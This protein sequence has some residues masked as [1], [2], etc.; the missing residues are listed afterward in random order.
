MGADPGDERFP[1]RTK[2]SSRLLAARFEQF[3]L[4]QP[5]SPRFCNARHSRSRGRGRRA[6]ARP[7]K[8]GVQQ[9]ARR[10]GAN[11]AEALQPSRTGRDEPAGQALTRQVL[12]PNLERAAAAVRTIAFPP[13]AGALRA[14]ALAT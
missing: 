13:S 3:E 5:V 14:I 12:S 11:A 9:A 4:S 6:L 7:P 2:P 10:V 1:N 8:T